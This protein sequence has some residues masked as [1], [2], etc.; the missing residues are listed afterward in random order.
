MTENEPIPRV[1]PDALN[2]PELRLAK[3]AAAG[4]SV[5]EIARAMGCSC[6]AVFAHCDAI[7]KKLGVDDYVM[8]V[9]W[10]KRYDVGRW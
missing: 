2:E 6:A 5:D 4:F 1:S 3:L 7:C 10:A 9:R 8:L